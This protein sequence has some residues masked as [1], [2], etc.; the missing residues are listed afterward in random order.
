MF[1]WDKG[2]LNTEQENAIFEKESV[3]L[4]ACPGSGKT[5]TLTYKIAYELSRLN[6]KKEFVIAITYTNNA[7]DEIKERVEILG[8]D[9]S[10]LWIGTI[11]SFCLEWILRPYSL[12]LEQLKH[13]FHI[14]SSHESEEIIT[15]LCK[16][17]KSQKITYWD[18]GFAAKPTGY[19]LTSLDTTKH[20]T[21]KKILHEYFKTL[22][23]NNQIDFEQILFYS[24]KLLKEKPLINTILSNLFPFI[25][26][27]EYQ[28][29]KEIQYHI[30]SSILR[31]NKGKSKTLIVGDPNQSI[32][33]SL[34]GFPMPKKDLESLLDFPLIELGLSLNYRSSTK[35]INY[36][37]FFKTYDNSI[38]P[39]GVFKD[40][41]GIISFNDKVDKLEY[42]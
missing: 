22:L 26:I 3:L 19:Y 6:S 42:N 32:Y 16:P 10:Q 17:Y 2:A 7:S 13:G 24:L 9:I 39:A 14:L 15:E 36:F 21:I 18:C 12:Y 29:T 23:K 31:A 28:D 41:D 37:D 5:R 40:Y 20:P 25:L 27:D 38:I 34:G 11:H 4:I 8:V 33:E 35:I 1:I 30:V